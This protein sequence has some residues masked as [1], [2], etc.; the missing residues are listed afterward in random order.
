MN[1]AQELL[2]IIPMIIIAAVVAIFVRIYR[3]SKRLGSVELGLTTVFE[4]EADGRFDM[5]NLPFPLVK[6]RYL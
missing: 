6:T 2:Q 4:E 3:C 1:S 5:L